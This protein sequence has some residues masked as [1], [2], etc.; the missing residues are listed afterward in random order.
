LTCGLDPFESLGFKWSTGGRGRYNHDTEP[1][2][3]INPALPQNDQV[4][5]DTTTVT[6]TNVNQTY[7]TET[8]EGHHHPPS[9]FPHFPAVDPQLLNEHYADVQRFAQ[10]QPQLVYLN[11]AYHMNQLNHQLNNSQNGHMR[12]QR[13]GQFMGQS[14]GQ[15]SGLQQE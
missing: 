8:H 3:P 14:V 6:A 1:H 4:D 11:Y 5:K 2:A 9:F 15:P 7:P 12:D 13:N 10:Q